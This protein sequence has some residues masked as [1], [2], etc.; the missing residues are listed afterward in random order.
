M[1][2]VEVAVDTVVVVVDHG[3]CLMGLVNS[4]V[5]VVARTEVALK[6]AVVASMTEEIEEVAIEVYIDFHVV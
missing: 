2:T 3:E 1:I 5:V 6:D 4:I